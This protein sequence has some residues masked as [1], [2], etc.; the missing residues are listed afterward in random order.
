MKGIAGNT[1]KV[2]L[3]SFERARESMS[4]VLQAYKD[5]R[6]SGKCM[7]GVD[8][9]EFPQMIQIV[10]ESER[11]YL[12]ALLRGESPTKIEETSEFR[13]LSHSAD[14]ANAI[15]YSHIYEVRLSVLNEL[16]QE[17]RVVG[18]LKMALLKDAK[19]HP[20]A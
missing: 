7:S 2:G 18:E 17:G 20:D 8:L 4:E 14:E 12:E 16:E 19:D 5:A 9:C 11:D 3:S 13:M 1:G 15:K 10:R 6:S